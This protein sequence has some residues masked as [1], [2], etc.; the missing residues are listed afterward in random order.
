ME[1]N[2]DAYYWIRNRGCNS[3][4]IHILK[5]NVVLSVSQFWNLTVRKNMETIEKVASKLSVS[6]GL[7][8]V[9]AVSSSSGGTYLT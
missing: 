6:A 3:V 8:G 7:S 4:V 1:E 2:G 9:N 5:R